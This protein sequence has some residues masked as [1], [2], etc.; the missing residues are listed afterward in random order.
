MARPFPARNPE[1]QMAGLI[2]LMYRAAAQP[3]LWATFLERL[4]AIFRANFSN[5]GLVTQPEQ[6]WWFDQPECLIREPQDV[7]VVFQQ[8]L[9]AE[10]LHEL[11][12]RWLVH[13][14][15]TRRAVQQLTQRGQSGGCDRREL[16]SDAEFDRL[17]F[18][19]EF[20][21]P[22]DYYHTL[23]SFLLG[24]TRELGLF[25]NVHRPRR[26]GAFDAGEVALFRELLPHLEDALGVHQQWRALR[27]QT[28]SR[29]L[30]LDAVARPCL[31]VDA[32]GRVLWANLA[33]DTLPER[34]DG[35]RVRGGV[36][37]TSEPSE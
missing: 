33:A 9:S 18:C 21:L 37:G 1:A 15:F 32:Q 34:G 35:L 25:L 31:T 17:P 6:A 30:A 8:G 28:R 19:H 29:A 26:Y 20:A 13:D 24:E 10:A 27:R 12:S 14:G 22:H 4:S 36:V 2:A 11:A 16:L 23:T 7:N 3:E 5:V